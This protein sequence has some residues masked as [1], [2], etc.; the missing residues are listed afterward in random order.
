MATA[1]DFMG[2]KAMAMSLL[3]LFLFVGPSEEK[4]YKV[5]DSSGWTTIGNVNYTAWASSKNFQVGDTIVFEY[6][7]QFH[8]VIE[9]SKADYQTCTA[10]SPLA[11]FTTGN[12]S[13]SIKK[14]GHLYFIC[15]FPG[16]CGAGQKVDIRVLKL[17]SSASPPT[18]LVAPSASP[19]ATSTPAPS[20][21]NNN[22]GLKTSKAL[23]YFIPVIV[24]VSTL[25]LSCL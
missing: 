6:N 3:A 24:S 25:V 13:I 17:S 21:H 8:N 4:V 20:Y 15:G 11:T 10:A 12:D 22:S 1:F 7:K 23:Y 9:V 16:H 18:S 5:G 14:T 19:T 2:A